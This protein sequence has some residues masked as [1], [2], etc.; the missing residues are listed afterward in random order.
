MQKIK[1][2]AVYDK[3][4]KQY[5]VPFFAHDDLFAQ[6]K[7]I[8]G[9]RDSNSIFAHFTDDFVLMKL[10]EVEISTGIINGDIDELG[11]YPYEIISANQIIL[12]AQEAAKKPQEEEK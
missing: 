12:E 4:A 1:M 8:M 11:K 7:F 2:Y 3:K 6:R 5:D 9:L 10:G